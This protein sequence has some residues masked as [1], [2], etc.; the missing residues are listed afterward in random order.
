M[1]SSDT[2]GTKSTRGRIT[3]RITVCWVTSFIILS[4]N[5]IVGYRY[6][7]HKNNETDDVQPSCWTSLP[8][9]HLQFRVSC[10]HSSLRNSLT[11]ENFSAHSTINLSPLLD[12]DCSTT[13]PV[14]QRKFFKR[15]RCEFFQKRIVKIPFVTVT[16]CA[17]TLRKKIHARVIGELRKQL[18]VNLWANIMWWKIDAA[19]TSLECCLRKIF[20]LYFAM[21]SICFSW[22]KPLSSRA[23]HSILIDFHKLR[24]RLHSQ[25]S[26]KQFMVK[27]YSQNFLWK[28]EI[29]KYWKWDF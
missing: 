26:L 16:K 13:T 18:R 2:S 8:S 24:A 19:S 6:C 21:A 22:G 3:I 29:W 12:L 9:V 10:R 17:L 11:A 4:A 20:K 23:F 25:P 27:I 28:F 5:Q 15:F 1:R 7:A 14:S